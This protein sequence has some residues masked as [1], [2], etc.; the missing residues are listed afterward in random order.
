MNPPRVVYGDNH[1]I[2]VDKPAGLATHEDCCNLEALTLWVRAWVKKSWGKE[3]AAF[4]H[5]VHRLDKDTSGLVLFAKTSKAL[6]R[7]N[8]SIRA[9]EFSKRY[10]ALVESTEVPPNGILENWLQRENFCTRVQSGRTGQWAQ[11]QFSRVTIHRGLCLLAV[12]PTTGRYHQIRAQLANMGWPIFGDV[13]YGGSLVS[14][15][16]EQRGIYL[17]HGGCT[18]PHPTTR[19]QL[20]VQCPLPTIWPKWSQEAYESLAWSTFKEFFAEKG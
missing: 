7:M 5:P 17:H 1:V 4:A 15:E 16:M 11:L 8:A 20:C 12:F 6:R 13:K 3:R 10:F 18:L 2:A 14:A 19:A 9:K